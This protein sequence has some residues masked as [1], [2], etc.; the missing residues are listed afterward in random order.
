MRRGK[1]DNE[2]AQRKCP[3]T[4]DIC[5]TDLFEEC[6]NFFRIAEILGK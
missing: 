4:G 5:V 1:Q 6:A 2:T 3:Q